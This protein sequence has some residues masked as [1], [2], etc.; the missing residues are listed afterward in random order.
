VKTAHL[1]KHE[2]AKW[3]SEL[4]A[5][6]ITADNI[7]EGLRDGTLLCKLASKVSEG[8][9]AWRRARA[10]ATAPDGGGGGGCGGSGGGG[11]G[12]EGVDHTR[13]IPQGPRP[14]NTRGH[15]A[16]ARENV[17]G[18][19]VTFITVT[20]RHDTY[21]S[22]PDVPSETLAR[23]LDAHSLGPG[24]RKHPEHYGWCAEP[25]CRRAGQLARSLYRWW[26]VVSV[27]N[28]VLARR[29]GGGQR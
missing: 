21:L 22:A 29:I 15:K 27:L 11:G 10:A 17:A 28:G 12:D 9:L 20:S 16:L 4:F 2:A 26:A 8:E 14:L 1:Y 19:D 3:L 24:L 23:S 18:D 13:P 6:D 5:S 25:P 7:L